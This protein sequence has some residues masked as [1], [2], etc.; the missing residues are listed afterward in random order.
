MWHIYHFYRADNDR[1]NL[2]GALCGLGFDPETG[3]GFYPEN[4]LEIIFTTK[5]SLLDVETVCIIF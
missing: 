4:D 3:Q 2:T 1:R 5:I